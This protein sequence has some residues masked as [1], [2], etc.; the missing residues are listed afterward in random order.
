MQYIFI[1]KRTSF[2]K[3]CSKRPK[4]LRLNTLYI[5]IPDFYW[6]LDVFFLNLFECIYL[7]FPFF[8]VF[9]L[10]SWFS[11]NDCFTCFA[12]PVLTSFNKYCQSGKWFK[13]GFSSSKVLHYSFQYKE[14]RICWFTSA[15][16]L[17]TA[18]VAVIFYHGKYSRGAYTLSVKKDG[19]N[20]SRYKKW[21]Q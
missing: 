5:R 2:L 9:L 15:F 19:K 4:F 14:K 16:R 7:F 20:V 18:S 8:L 6:P 11:E 10:Q 12:K 3:H 17:Y 13:S 1:S 21:Q